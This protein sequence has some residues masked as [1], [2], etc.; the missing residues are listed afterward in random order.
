MGHR[1]DQDV[2]GKN[3]MCCSYQNWT[4]EFSARRINTVLLFIII[5]IIEF[6][7]PD[8][9]LEILLLNHER[10]IIYEAYEPVLNV[11]KK[12]NLKI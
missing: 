5:F 4:P 12:I 11:Q 8:L 3:E 2:L 9:K 7:L 10:Y 1:G 6:K